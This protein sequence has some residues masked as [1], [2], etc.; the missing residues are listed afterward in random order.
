[1]KTVA[2]GGGGAATNAQAAAAGAEGSSAV[3]A[4]DPS[5]EPKILGKVK[6]RK[7]PKPHQSEADSAE[8]RRLEQRVVKLK[9]EI[10]RRKALG[11]DSV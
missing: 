1:M 10:E 9:E 7:G 6:T 8:L 4:V 11:T 2:G 3:P 5:R